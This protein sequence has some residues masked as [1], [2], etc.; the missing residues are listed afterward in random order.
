[1]TPLII[2]KPNETVVLSIEDF[3]MQN[4]AAQDFVV[5]IESKNT[6]VI[7]PSGE[8]MKGS[9]NF[10][11]GSSVNEGFVLPPQNGIFLSRKYQNGVDFSKVDFASITLK[12]FAKEQGYTA[13]VVVGTSG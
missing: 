9:P 11:V 3:D 10:Y 13:Y 4:L 7:M 6:T 1:M 2:N 5:I 8:K 12:Y